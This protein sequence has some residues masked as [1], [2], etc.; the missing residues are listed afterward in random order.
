MLS[1]EVACCS[2]TDKHRHRATQDQHPETTL[3]IL[4][5]KCESLT[6]ESGARGH[7]AA[8]RRSTKREMKVISQTLSA[9]LLNCISNTFADAD[10]DHMQTTRPGHIDYD[11]QASTR[12]MAQEIMAL[13]AN[14][15]VT[16]DDDERRALEED[17]TGKVLWLCWCGICQE[18]EQLLPEVVNYIR[19]EG[20]TDGLKD[21]GFIIKG[22]CTYPD[23]NQAHLQRIMIDAGTGTSKHQL[24][25]GARARSTSGTAVPERQTHA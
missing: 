22:L 16:K 7:V 23:D 15:G 14:L 18:A 13:Q 19:K 10:S 20:M 6:T 5:N 1:K 12:S 9:G 17:V 4:R 11:R 3:T 8:E 25:L 21:I 2:S 24:L